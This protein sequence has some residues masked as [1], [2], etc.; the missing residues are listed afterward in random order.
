M[1]I[2]GVNYLYNPSDNIIEINETL[3]NIHWE[4]K[5]SIIVDNNRYRI[6]TSPPIGKSAKPAI[7]S[8]LACL[9]REG[10]VEQICF[11]LAQYAIESCP[12]PKDLGDVTRLLADTQKKWLES[13]FEKLKSLKDRNVYEVM[14]LPKRR[15]AIKNH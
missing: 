12:I 11:L 14:D 3:Y 15:K 9:A 4:D 7:T 8:Y 1:R 6:D 5:H 13:C 2:N 10:R